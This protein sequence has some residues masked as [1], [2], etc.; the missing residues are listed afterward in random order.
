MVRR[1]LWVIEEYGGSGMIQLVVHEIDKD[2]SW[3]LWLVAPS[4]ADVMVRRLPLGSVDFSELRRAMVSSLDEIERQLWRVW[5]DLLGKGLLDGLSVGQSVS[6]KFS[7]KLPQQFQWTHPDGLIAYWMKAPVRFLEWKSARK[8][9]AHSLDAIQ[10]VL[11]EC[12]SLVFQK[13]QWVPPYLVIIFRTT[14]RAMGSALPPREESSDR[15]LRLSVGLLRSYSE[16]SIRRVIL[17]ELAHFK[18]FDEGDLSRVDGGHD[19]RFCELLSMV[20]PLVSS[21]PDACRYFFDDIDDAIFANEWGGDPEDV[22]VQ[23]SRARRGSKSRLVSRSGRRN[24][25]RWFGDTMLLL[26]MIATLQMGRMRKVRVVELDPE[27]GSSTVSNLRS[28]LSLAR[29]RISAMI[30]ADDSSRAKRAHESLT[31][32]L[33][34][35]EEQ[36]ARKN[37]GEWM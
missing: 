9:S 12:L 23:I 10:R 17:H 24:P 3:R 35:D 29:K 31:E 15:R 7:L 8:G 1:D 36:E 2:G 6:L 27:S 30:A 33:R 25:S 34:E 21:E 28:A 20:D 11:Q 18:R 13:W 4:D 14:G 37:M 19:A 32:L 5:K 26:K 22:E 16:S